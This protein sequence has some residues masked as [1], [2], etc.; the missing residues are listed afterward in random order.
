MSDEMM[1]RLMGD[2]FPICR[3][4]TGEGVR[5][6][7]RILQA[8]I[9]LI[10]HEVPSGT[11]V[12]DWTVPNEWNIRDA[13]VSNSKGERVIDFHKHN[14]H[15]LNYSTPVHTRLNL[16]ELKPHL[17][18]ST[19]HPDWIP[20]R[21]SYY[22]PNWG[23]CLAHNDLLKLPE[24]TYEVVIDSTLEP[25]FLT[26]GELSLPGETEDEVIISTHVCHPSMC[27]DNLSGIVVATALARM[28]LDKPRRHSYRFI[29]VPGTIGSITWLARN[30][31]SLYKIRHG[32]VIS[33]L[34]DAAGFTYKRTRAGNAVIDR[35]VEQALAETGTEYR[36]LDFVPYGYDE[37][38]FNSPGIQ[39]PVGAFW[40]SQHGTYNQYHTSADDLTFVQPHQLQESLQ[41]L[42]TITDI[43]ETNRT[44]L[45]LKPMGEPQLGKRGLYQSIAGDSN[46]A[47]LQSALLWVLN[48][49]DGTHD[50]L[51]I[52][53]KSKLPF[54]TIAQ[55][56]QLLAKTDLLKIHS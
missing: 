43:L 47:T 41:M 8:H 14:L 15:I 16:A 9:P 51:A 20:Y 21:T 31:D 23:F 10:I 2:L 1:M 34:G 29:F 27:N 53:S 30:Q 40:R 38:Q 4:I 32:L 56:A 17:Y 22:S 26:Y 6:T 19:E 13:F 5:K 25:G 45:N 28:L 12:F 50:L 11:S 42:A 33:N 7:L 54:R 52:A 44:Y 18:T 55:A 37:R 24:D 46:H 36:V 48:F 35:L 39:L 3:S 49:S